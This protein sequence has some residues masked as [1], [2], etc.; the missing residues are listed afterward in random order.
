MVGAKKRALRSG[1]NGTARRVE[2]NAG[3]TV[4][5]TSLEVNP[6]KWCNGSPTPP[7]PHPCKRSAMTALAYVPA[8][9]NIA[10]KQRRRNHYFLPYWCRRV[11]LR[12]QKR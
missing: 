10:L 1:H 2:L 7:T 4:V 11:L 3:G 12:L 5:G 8:E 6:Q 9:N